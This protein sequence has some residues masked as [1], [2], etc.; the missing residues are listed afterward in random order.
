MNTKLSIFEAS[1]RLG[2]SARHVQRL[3]NK[4]KLPGAIQIDGEWQIPPTAHPKL[5][6]CQTPA[7]IDLTDVPKD[8]LDEALRRRGLLD[9]CERFCGAAVRNNICKLTAMTKFCDERDIPLRTMQRWQRAF[10]ERGMPGLIDKR[11]GLTG[12][13]SITP[14][15]FEAFK[16]MYLT[17]QKLSVKTCLQ[18][19]LY[20]AQTQKTGWV[21]PSLRTMQRLAVEKIPEPVLILHRE[22][23]AAYEARCAPYILIDPNSVEPGAVW[24]GDHHKFDCW[25]WHRGNWLRPW[26]TAWEDYRS[27]KIMGRHI[28]VAPNSTTILLAMRRGIEQFGPPESVKIDN[29]RDYDSQLFTGKTK[30]QRRKRIRLTPDEC[31]SVTGIYARLGIGVSFAIPYNAKAKKIERWFATVCSQFTKTIPTYC[32][33]DTGRRPEDVFEYMKTDKAKREALTLETFTAAVDQYIA[34]YNASAHTGRGMDGQTPDAVF[35]QRTS[36]RVVDSDVLDLLMQVWSPVLT[37][38]RNGIIVNGFCYGQFNSTLHEYFGKPVRAAYDPDDMK[39]VN[40]YDANTYRLITIAENPELM[41][42]YGPVG[43]E[44]LREAMAQKSRNLKIV[45]R[46]PRAAKVSAMSI[47]DLTLAASQAMTIETPEQLPANVKPVRTPLDGQAKEYLRQRNQQAVR[48]A[49]GGESMTRLPDL[50]MDLA[51]P[52]KTNYTDELMVMDLLDN[53]EPRDDIDL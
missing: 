7:D 16:S 24:V 39:R 2:R 4:G 3:C 53:K 1:E 34:I 45:K 48:K 9:E 47:M 8:K 52:S 23:L 32:G 33:P 17:Q 13:E 37:V 25:I 50:E 49:A 14:A 38:G 12:S 19:V 6:G 20:V 26:I 18:N 31:S 10:K 44:S 41:A 46:Y 36:R 51:M 15:A 43:E 27:R 42:Q 35:A 30:K 21:I 11:G 28:S 40:V 22:G 5:R 29:G